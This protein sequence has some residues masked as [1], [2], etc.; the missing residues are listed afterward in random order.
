MLERREKFR[1]RAI[2]K[3]LVDRIS[4]SITKKLTGH[5]I[6][7]IGIHK[8]STLLQAGDKVLYYY[9]EYREFG[10]KTVYEID[11]ISYKQGF[12]YQG[13]SWYKVGNDLIPSS[14]IVAIVLEK[15]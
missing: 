1:Q 6:T 7:I 13:D 3:F 15:K 2:R 11:T 9:Y 5:K 8:E 4:A 10:P 14:N 12:L